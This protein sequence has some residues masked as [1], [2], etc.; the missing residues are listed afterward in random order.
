MM[1]FATILLLIQSPEQIVGQVPQDVLIK[2]KNNSNLRFPDNS[3]W[4]KRRNFRKE[5]NQRMR[6]FHNLK[7]PRGKNH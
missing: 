5:S 1:D 6:A 2:N 4:I 7:Q 3:P